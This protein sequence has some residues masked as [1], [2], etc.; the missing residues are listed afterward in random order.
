MP[1]RDEIL[2]RI[3]KAA[4]ARGMQFVQDRQGGN[5]TLYDLDGLMI[6]VGRHRQFGNRYAETVYKQCAV[7][8]GKDWWKK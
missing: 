8:L 3:K 5:H 4:K 7:K 2:S 1:S 6:T